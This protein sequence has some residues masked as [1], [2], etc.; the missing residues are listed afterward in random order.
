MSQA[1]QNRAFNTDNVLENKPT[2]Q[3]PIW[4]TLDIATR[5]LK[6]VCRSAV[7][8]AYTIEITPIVRASG[9]K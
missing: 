4:A 3:T 2:T 6:S 5:H 7:S 1:Q 8:E 9:A